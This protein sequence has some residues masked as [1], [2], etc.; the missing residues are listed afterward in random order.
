MAAA[1]PLGDTFGVVELVTELEFEL[2]GVGLTPST[3]VV[4]LHFPCGRAEGELE[5][6]ED[7]VSERGCNNDAS[8]AGLEGRL[9]V[10]LA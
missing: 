9:R 6:V 3:R 10:G 5:D 4:T 7:F 2:D 8:K 1:V